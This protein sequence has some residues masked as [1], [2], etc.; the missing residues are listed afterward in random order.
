MA[1]DIEGDFKRPPFGR[2]LPNIRGWVPWDLRSLFQRKNRA[3]K[4]DMRNG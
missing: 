1:D 2:E 4:S 3:R